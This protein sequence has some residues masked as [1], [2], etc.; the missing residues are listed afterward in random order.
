M[1]VLPSDTAL[2]G[3]PPVAV[4]GNPMFQKG[5][6]VLPVFALYPA[7]VEVL[8]IVFVFMSVK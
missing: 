1:F 3:K 6:V 8:K 5:V 4:E 2:P 7:P